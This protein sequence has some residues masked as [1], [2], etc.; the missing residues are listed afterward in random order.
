MSRIGEDTTRQSRVNV[1]FTLLRPPL[2]DRMLLEATVLPKFRLEFKLDTH[3]LPPM[4]VIGAL[5]SSGGLS[6]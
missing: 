1:A 5:A 4:T 6:E 2:I 3:R